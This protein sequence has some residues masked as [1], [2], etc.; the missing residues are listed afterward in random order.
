MTGRE[1]ECRGLSE[2][3]RRCRRATHPY[4]LLYRLSE[5]SV[6]SRRL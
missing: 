2:A 3:W 6:G 4:V 5:D 1:A